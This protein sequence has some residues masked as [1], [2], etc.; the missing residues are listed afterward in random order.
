MVEKLIITEEVQK[1][2]NMAF[3]MKRTKATFPYK[4]EDHDF[5]HEGDYKIVRKDLD[6]GILGEAENGKIVNIDVSIPKG[7]KKE[8]EVATH[9][10]H[11]QKEMESGKLAY[12]D[13]SVTDDIAGKKYKREDGK[14]IDEDS[15][16]AYVEGDKNL[17]HEKRAYKASNKIK[18]S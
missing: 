14:L 8:K 2:I 1:Q 9:E 17:P 16:I 11:H 10:I 18:N 3:K 5:V 7:S 15:G 12:D 13:D 4:G 6:D